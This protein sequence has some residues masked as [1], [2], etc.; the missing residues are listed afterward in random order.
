MDYVI[1]VNSLK[2]KV[3]SGYFTKSTLLFMTQLLS[4]ACA[5]FSS[6]YKLIVISN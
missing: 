4:T 1:A 2:S 3:Y 6:S 5:S